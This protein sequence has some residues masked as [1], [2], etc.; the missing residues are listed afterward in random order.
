[1]NIPVDKELVR[2][3]WGNRLY[4]KLLNY[5]V[6]TYQYNNQ[7]TFLWGYPF[8]IYVDPSSRCTLRCPFCAV[9]TQH[10]PKPLK[11]MPL[12]AF[13]KLMDELGPYLLV[14]ELFVKGEP[15]MNKDIYDMI[16]CCK[17][18]RMFT[19]LSSNMQ[20]LDR[21]RAERM[22]ESGLDHLLASIDGATQESYETYRKGG[23]LDLALTNMRHV[24]EAKKRLGKT[25]PLVEWKFIVFRHNEGELAKAK[26]MAAEIGVD[27][28]CFVP[29]MVGNAPLKPAEA[30]WLPLSSEF[31]MYDDGGANFA[32]T[33]GRLEISSVCNLP[34]MSLTVDPLSNIQ[35]CCRCNEKQHD[36][37]RMTWG[38]FW[39]V[40]NGKR[41]R[42]SRRHIKS[43]IP[44][45]ADPTNLCATCTAKSSLNA[46]LPYE[47]YKSL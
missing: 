24:V 2:Y 42:D 18:Y 39:R 15:L 36:H 10:Y 19:R 37:G 4:R 46:V 11:D 6:T 40:W 30:D 22:V 20:F 47:F 44:T 17:K 29:A 27:R 35:T 8:Q 26:Q 43:G 16:A 45:E 14:A 3:L 28:L 12:K 13:Q 34:W 25:T 1:M 5:L 9:G 32:T 7:W 31:R 21:A 41:Y 33:V 23:D 38:F